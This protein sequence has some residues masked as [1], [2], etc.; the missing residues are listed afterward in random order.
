MTTSTPACRH[1]TKSS[2]SAGNGGDCVE[3]ALDQAGVYVR[4]SKDPTGPE[5]LLS[6]PDWHVF[7]EAATAGRDHPHIARTASGV[8]VSD[9]RDRT[10]GLTFTHAEWD[11]FVAGARAGEC[12]PAA[13]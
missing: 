7:L 3:W 6:Y 11:A 1:Y 12:Q 5:L 2:R 9:R 13:A 4:D 8:H 10:I